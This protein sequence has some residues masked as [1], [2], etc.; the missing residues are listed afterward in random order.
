MAL[1]VLPAV[2]TFSLGLV[3]LS[4]L[5]PNPVQAAR[6]NPGEEHS[7]Q[8][9]DPVEDWDLTGAKLRVQPQ[10]QTLF[11]IS[12]SGST[13]ILQDATV[14]SATGNDAL[15]LSR[16]T[17]TISGTDVIG[18]NAYGL[19]AIRDPGDPQP[20]S[21]VELL[22]SRVAGMGRGIN[23]TFGSTVNLT[24]TEVFGAGNGLGGPTSGGV[25]MTLV[26]ARAQLLGSSVLGSNRGVLMTGDNVAGGNQPVLIVDD[27][28]LIGGGQGPAVTVLSSGP[29]RVNA[30]LALGNGSRMS[31]GNAVLVEA[32][33]DPVVDIN[34]DNS[35]LNGHIRG[36]PTSQIN[37]TMSGQASL[38]GNL[39]DIASL[40]MDNSRLDGNLIQSPGVPVTLALTHGSV[41]TGTVSGASVL[42]VSSGALFSMTGNSSVE[43]LKLNDGTV[44]LS[45]GGPGFRVLSAGSLSGQGTFALRTDLAGHLGDLLDITGQASGSHT[46]RVQNSGV[47]PA[48]DSHAQRLVHTGSGDAQFA[49]PGGQVDVGTFVYRL[50]QRGTDWFLV[51]AREGDGGE[52]GDGGDG[53]DGSGQNPDPVPTPGT[54]A[55]VG[56]FNAAPTVWYGEASSLRS[57][58]GE[59]RRGQA[60]SG[61]WA[62][63]YGNRYRVEQDAALDYR[64]NQQGLAFGIDVPLGAGSHDWLVG[65]TGGYSRSTL[66]MN[67]GTRGTVDSFYMGLYSTWLSRQGW[68]LDGLL[69][70]NHLHNEADVRMSDGSKAAGDYNSLGLGASLEAGRHIELGS[71]WFVEPFVQISGLWVG[72]ESYRLDNGMQ[73]RSNRADSLLGKAGA[74][75]GR[76]I[77]LSRGGF[78]QPYLKLAAVHEFV[79][80][81]T[82]TVN[83]RYRFANDLSGSRTEVGAGVALQWSDALQLHADTEY[84]SGEAID[85]P[86]GLNLGLR[87]VW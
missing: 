73:A 69:K 3:I 65:L 70:V 39:H 71:N 77:A 51:Q 14:R 61:A 11:I 6:L 26:G 32:L 8:P 40:S 67:Q 82:V 25:G 87:Y 28:S 76:T 38:T 9:G 18:D 47:D 79:D 55:V 83:D 78:V 12:H 62:R 36:T 33:G 19:S 75:A 1:H 49:V 46:L 63:A 41:M 31:A 17:A 59:L 44:E 21:H 64:Q 16:S 4:A 80:G 23:A 35:A 10:A 34:V 48:A 66:N 84:S 20:G 22:D 24:R 2:G 29:E 13:L 30:A 85:Q 42:D 27:H 56:L 53:D 68:Y 52:G 57:R 37:L 74:V 43:T 54:R 50:E 58:M 45:S 86:W 60:R 7:V 15:N 72:G 81:N 5:P